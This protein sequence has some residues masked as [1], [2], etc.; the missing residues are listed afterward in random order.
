M[1]HHFGVAGGLEDRPGA[2]QL[3]AQLAGV[4]EVA[5]VP[6]R[7]LAVGAIDQEGLRVLDRAL[8]GGRVPG[9]TDRQVAAKAVDGFFLEGIRHLTHAADDA[10]LGAVTDGNAGALLPAVLQRVEPERGQACGSRVPEDAEDA[11]LVFELVMRLQ[12]L[13]SRRRPLARLRGP[14]RI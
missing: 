12:R 14:C 11:A 2:D 8:A 7:D 5:V 6:D 1:E 10:H 3:V 9:V 4:D 13:A